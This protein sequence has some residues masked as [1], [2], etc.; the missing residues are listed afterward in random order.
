MSSKITRNI[1]KFGKRTP[2]LKSAC[3]NASKNGPTFHFQDWEGKNPHNP[4][5]Q[6][7]D[8]QA[9]LKIWF[10]TS[11]TFIFLIEKHPLLQF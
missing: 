8:D 4:V 7:H 2:D 6:D 1:E 10:D 9:L 5:V 3:K 11:I